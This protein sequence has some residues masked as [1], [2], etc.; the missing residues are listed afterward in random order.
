[1]TGPRIEPSALATLFVCVTL[2]PLS[3]Y[4]I[5]LFTLFIHFFLCFREL[6]SVSKKMHNIYKVEPR[7]PKKK[8]NFFIKKNYFQAIRTQLSQI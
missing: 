7:K 6:N 5:L 3:H 1:M 8:I 2:I 4:L